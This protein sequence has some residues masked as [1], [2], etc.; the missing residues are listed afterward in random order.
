MRAL[1][2]RSHPA[3]PVLMAAA[4]ALSGCKGGEE[5]AT[6][7]TKLEVECIGMSMRHP[8]GGYFMLESDN[9]GRCQLLVSDTVSDPQNVTLLEQG[10]GNWGSPN[11]A[12]LVINYAEKTWVSRAGSI[13]FS[14]WEPDSATG[15]Y[16]LVGVESSTG[17][18]V[19]LS[20]PISFCNYSANKQCPYQTS[21]LSALDKRL[22][23]VGPDG[24]S[25]DATSSRANECRVLID[26][27]TS[28]VRVDVQLAILNGVNIARF[29]DRCGSAVPPSAGFVFMAP[30][31]GGPG[32]Y[33]PVSSK[34]I[35]QVGDGPAYLPDFHLVAPTVYWL[36]NC[37]DSPE[38][39]MD[40]HPIAGTACS[41]TIADNPGKFQIQCTGAEHSETGHF[42]VKQGS[43]ELSSDC[44]VRYVE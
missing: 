13:S 6:S 31:V 16:D 32:S 25:A 24:F 36:G 15:T 14:Q 22:S 17:E 42:Y 33:G 40:V 5:R 35:A 37:A 34:P 2:S 4:L 43:F 39:L 9:G 10:G 20:G 44:D 11:T 18:E 21:G 30:N 41:F 38:R 1:L 29:R 12:A 8:L 26:K 23:F 7:G 27:K 28:A 19:K 3:A